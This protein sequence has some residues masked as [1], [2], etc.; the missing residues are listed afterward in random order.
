MEILRYVQDHPG[1]TVREV[2]EHFRQT[3][4][5]VR[6][7]ILNVMERLRKKGHLGRKKVDGIFRY[8]AC[9][10]KARLLRAL[11]EDFVERT[12]SGSVSPF[13]AYLVQNARINDEGLRELKQLV[14]DLDAQQR[15]EKRK[16]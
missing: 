9:L 7:T 12:L 11:V 5:H 1:V 13:L 15:V 6:T 2:A 10:P 3:K 16:S 14:R 4:G 8:E